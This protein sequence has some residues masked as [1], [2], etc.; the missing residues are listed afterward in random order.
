MKFPLNILRAIEG[1]AV[2]REFI[3]FFRYVRVALILGIVTLSVLIV[4]FLIITAY[5]LMHLIQ[6]N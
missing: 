2:T 3:K 6:G 4:C 1:L 5:F